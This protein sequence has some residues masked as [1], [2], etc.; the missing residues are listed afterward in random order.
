MKYNPLSTVFE[1]EA[2]DDLS[3]IESPMSLDAPIVIVEF[4][5]SV[6]LQSLIFIL[7]SD[8]ENSGIERTEV[9]SLICDNVA[10]QIVQRHV[11]IQ[12]KN[13]LHIVFKPLML[14]GYHEEL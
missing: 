9:I 14:Y 7:T 6:F 10:C 1:I 5:I 8:L 2:R 3:S 4:K 12:N 13:F 11:N